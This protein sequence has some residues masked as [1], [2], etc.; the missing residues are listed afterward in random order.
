MMKCFIKLLA[1]CVC[2]CVLVRNDPLTQFVA[3]VQEVRNSCPRLPPTVFTF[4]KQLVSKQLQRDTQWFPLQRDTHTHTPQG[5]FV[6]T[7]QTV[8]TKGWFIQNTTVS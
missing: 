7:V 1:V 6:C 8:K 5:F 4:L 3:T 2:V